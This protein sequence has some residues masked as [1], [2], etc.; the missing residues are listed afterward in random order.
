MNPEIMINIGSKDD[1]IKA[2][3]K[4]LGR[5]CYRRQNFSKENH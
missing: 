1:Y 5:Y 3:V 4:G 2:D